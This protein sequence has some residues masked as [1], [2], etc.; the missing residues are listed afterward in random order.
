MPEPEPN[1]NTPCDPRMR[2]FR[3]RAAVEEVIALIDDRVESLGPEHLGLFE[4]AGRVLAEQIDARADVPPFDRAAMDGFALRGE[5]TFGADSYTPA[6]F[7]LIGRSRPGRG[8][9]GN[10]GA[11]EAVEITTGAPLPAGAD[12]VVKVEAARLAGATVSVVEPVPPG[13]HVSRHGEDLARGAPVF[14][15]G[16]RLRPQDLGLLSALGCARVAV[17][18]RP[19]VVVLVT[20]D[21][22]LPVGAPAHE[23]SIADMNSVMVAA[24]V[25][26]DGGIAEVVGPLADDPKA[27]RA[28]LEEARTRADAIL[29]SGGS[30][31][32]PE[33]HAPALL[34]ELGELP[35]HG[36]A[37]RPASPAG[38]GFW[39]RL[40]LVLLPGNPVSC[41]CAYDFFGGRVIRR[42]AGRRPEWPYRIVTRPLKR[43]LTSALGRVDYCRVRIQNGAVE[44]I[45]TSGASILSST[46][47]AD[48][49][50]V[51]PANLEGFAPGTLVDV[52]QYDDEPSPTDK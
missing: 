43:K 4:A 33:D 38:L 40:P 5:E 50:V 45:A 26:R 25:A 39:G 1:P 49:F 18:R 3:T 48:G 6:V 35:V 10:V 29:V 47:R 9:A 44:P 31:T 27:I 42:L 52:W 34:A 36:V 46:T 23:E 11:G 12:A 17:V 28:A 7:R 22:L 20:G 30:S 14:V 32:G 41:L 15:A 37:L 21:E 2:G 24:L 13:R 16:R 51:V 8:F 19:R